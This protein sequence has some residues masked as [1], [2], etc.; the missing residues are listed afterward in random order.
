M[1]NVLNR[2]RELLDEVVIDDARDVIN[3]PLNG[4]S[5]LFEMRL[6]VLDLEVPYTPLENRLG[7][8]L[9]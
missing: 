2:R 3:N 1:D 5:E 7:F 9:Q 4:T 6:D 8:R